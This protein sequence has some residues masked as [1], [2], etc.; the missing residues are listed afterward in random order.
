MIPQMQKKKK[1]KKK[2]NENNYWIIG[3]DKADSS[4]TK[5]AVT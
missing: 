4:A 5:H 1:K 2:S 3:M